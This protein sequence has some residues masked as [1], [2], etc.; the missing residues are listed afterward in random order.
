MIAMPMS[1]VVVKDAATISLI[2]TPKALIMVKNE[3][4]NIPTKTYQ[5]GLKP[6]NLQKY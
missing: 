5:S 1:F 6:T 2:F 3:I 4:V